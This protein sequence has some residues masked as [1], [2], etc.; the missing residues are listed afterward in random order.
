MRSAVENLRNGTP[1]FSNRAI[2]DVKEAEPPSQFRRA[3][4]AAVLVGLIGAIAA[5]LPGLL[6]AIGVS[7]RNETALRALELIERRE[8]PGTRMTI[9]EL[10]LWTGTLGGFG[11]MIGGAV[12]WLAAGFRQP[13]NSRVVG[14]AAGAMWAF[15][16]AVFGVMAL[17]LP[18]LFMGAVIGATVMA[19]FGAAIGWW[20]LLLLLKP[21][22]WFLRSIS[23]S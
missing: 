14:A 16:G 15:D 23:K 8:P 22:A 3:V 10:A 21:I 2:W 19:F 6:I 4:A 13:A 20:G 17:G 5:A 7:H 1:P 9:D 12:G 11:G 18:G